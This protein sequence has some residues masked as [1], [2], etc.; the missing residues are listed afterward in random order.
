MHTQNN[1]RKTKGKLSKAFLCEVKAMV[2]TLLVFVVG[3]TAFFLYSQFIRTPEDSKNVLD[4]SYA[5]LASPC[6]SAIKESISIPVD[7]SKSLDNQNSSL[8]ENETSK[9]ETSSVKKDIKSLN[10]DKVSSNEEDVESLN[11]VANASDN[12]DLESSSEN[13][14]SS[15]EEN[16]ESSSEND[17]SS[18]EE[19]LEPS[20]ENDDSSNEDKVSSE[21]GDDAYFDEQDIEKSLQDKLSS[22]YI[23]DGMDMSQPIGFTSEELRYLL[24]NSGLI[25]NEEVLSKLPEILVNTIEQ[26]PVNELFSLS[27]MSL[28]SG[29]FTSELAQNKNNFGGMLNSDGSGIYFDTVDEGLQKAIMCVH[30][31]LKGSNTIYEIQD[32]YCPPDADGNNGYEWSSLVLSIMQSYAYTEVS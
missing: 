10:K 29:Y 16:L 12:E 6:L 4:N 20:S 15:D 25:S 19:N 14:D 18:D 21:E 7:L 8:E 3:F 5:E 9:D 31:N 1:G 13:D 28:E 23:Y 2:I 11:D 22:I 17:D 27:V 30:F 32:T 26:Y 24:N